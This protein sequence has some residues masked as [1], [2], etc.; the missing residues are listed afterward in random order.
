MIKQDL[1]FRLLQKLGIFFW[2]E[3]SKENATVSETGR[4]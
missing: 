3:P 1:V 4:R 2:S